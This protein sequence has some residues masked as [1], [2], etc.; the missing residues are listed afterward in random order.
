MRDM[1]TP[2]VYITEV[3]T[4]NDFVVEVAS[5]IPAFIGFTEKATHIDGTSLTNIAIKIKSWAQY[6][7]FFGGQAITKFTFEEQST[8][9]LGL[10]FI[11]SSVTLGSEDYKISPYAKNYILYHAIRL[12]FDNGGSECF[13][14]SVGSYDDEIT[15]KA[16]QTG[17]DVLTKEQEPTILVAP[18]AVK[19][20]ASECYQLQ[21]A[22]LKHCGRTMKNRVAI[23]DVYDGHLPKTVS[24][25]PIAEFRQG[26]GEDC[27]DYAA[28][29][30][31]WLNT[32][33]VPKESISYKN[34]EVTCIAKLIELLK[35]ELVSPLDLQLTRLKRK[36]DQRIID[37][38][39]HQKDQYEALLEELKTSKNKQ[40][41]P[42]SS[43]EQD[44]LNK[45]LFNV[46]KI[47]AQLIN[48]IYAQI[49]LLP[50]SAIM[51]G[52][53]CQVDNNEGVWKAPANV[54]LYSAI[55]LPVA[56]SDAE[57]ENLNSAV[58]G[59]SINAIRNFSG[60]GILVWGARTLDA[61]SA[62]WRYLPVKR[63][64]IMIE[65]SI[66]MACK[67]FV[68]QSN[69]ANT[70]TSLRNNIKYFLTEIWKKGALCGA[71][72]S[73]A[74]RVEVGLGSTMTANDILE[75]LL[76]V[77]V[78]VALTQPAEFIVINIQQQMQKS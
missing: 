2:S 47:F 69:D 55:D 7:L 74:F 15:L 64:A 13:L 3:A 52:V 78:C 41:Q 70:W 36:D 14:I 46:S 44:H 9:S 40:G 23:L 37:K 48:E 68:F 66:I 39:K 59:K 31:P 16:M 8:S 58:S 73:D 5:D 30:Y 1:K 29:Y 56:I 24:R 21:Q 10:S 27:L 26:I 11:T 34:L 53:L 42:L 20:A 45:V 35:T 19:L 54:A 50:P 61:N 25:D 57:Q 43:E 32:T 77:R 28:A 18:E 12:F 67:P 6:Y 17:L 63:T 51:A 71:S 49:N 75:G 33:V 4:L 22:M 65:Q 60:Q 62:D 38:I 76:N 72:P